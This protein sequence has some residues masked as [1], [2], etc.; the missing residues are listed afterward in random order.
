MPPSV[1]QTVSFKVFNVMM[2][3]IHVYLTW[4]KWFEYRNIRKLSNFA[5]MFLGIPIPSMAISCCA[6]HIY[7]S[8]VVNGFGKRDKKKGILNLSIDKYRV[9]HVVG[10][11]RTSK[12]LPDLAVPRCTLNPEISDC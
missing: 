4:F 6:K 11:F 9:V 1:V 2:I 8:D 10:L 3:C 5:S 7:T 12:T